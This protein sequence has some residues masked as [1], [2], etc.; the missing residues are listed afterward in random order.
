MDSKRKEVQWSVG[1]L[2]YVKL[3]PYHQTTL[4]QRVNEKLA[5]RF[6]GPFKSIQKMGPVAYKLELPEKA[7]IHPIFHVSLLKKA[8]GPRLFHHPFPLP[9]L[10]TWNYWYNHRLLIFVPLQSWKHLDKKFL[11]IGMTSQLMR[12]HGNLLIQSCFLILTLRTRLLLGQ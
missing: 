4:T 6:Y 1:D 5:P 7:R 11:F 3:R 2:V 10:M 8:V 9:Y 12:T